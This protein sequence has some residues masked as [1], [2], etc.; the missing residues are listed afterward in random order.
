MAGYSPEY[1]TARRTLLDVLTALRDHID[2]SRYGISR[3]PR[4]PTNLVAPS[5][6]YPSSSR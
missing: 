1:V 3:T 6:R 4:Q 5:T 2:T